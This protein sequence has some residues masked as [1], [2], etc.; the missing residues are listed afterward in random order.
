LV[1]FGPEFDYFLPSKPL[2]CISSR[3]CAVK[4]LAYDLSSVFLERFRTMSFPL[5]TA[6]IVSHMFVYVV[7]SFSLNSKKSLISFL[8]LF[9]I[10][11]FN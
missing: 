4:L 11:F 8:F 1:D 3:A 6:F 2:E 9:V 10:S 5:S 7:P